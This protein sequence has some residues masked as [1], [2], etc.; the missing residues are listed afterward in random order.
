VFNDVIA[1]K[2][3]AARAQAFV[4]QFTSDLLFSD[5]R[6]AI[7]AGIRKTEFEGGRKKFVVSREIPL[8]SLSKNTRDA[9]DLYDRPRYKRAGV[10]KNPA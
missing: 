7:I 2:I 6:R 1:L 10:I 9:N 5:L 4:K 3:F 8:S